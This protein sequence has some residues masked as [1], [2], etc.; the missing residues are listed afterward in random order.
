MVAVPTLIT[1]EVCMPAR[2]APSASGSS[3]RSSRAVRGSPNARAESRSD[4]GMAS[5]PAQVLRT[6]G[7]SP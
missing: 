3:M 2:I 7:S 4:C 6:I 5:R 1:A